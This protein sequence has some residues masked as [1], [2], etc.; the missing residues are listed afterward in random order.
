MSFTATVPC[1]S[2]PVDRVPDLVVLIAPAAHR[3]LGFEID[4]PHVPGS[5]S[6]ALLHRLQQL[7][8]VEVGIPEVP[9][10]DDVRDQLALPHV[11]LVDVVGRVREAGAFSARPWEC[12]ARKASPLLSR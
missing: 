12:I 6:A 9:T 4:Q 3:R 2:M 8:A 7:S 1:S 5:E 10:V 11:V